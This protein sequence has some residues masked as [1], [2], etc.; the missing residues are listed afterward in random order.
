MDD[1]AATVGRDE[2]RGIGPGNRTLC[3]FLVSVVGLF[4]EL[5][6]I[7]W[8]STEIRIF[9]Y[10]Q[11]TV[12]VVC[13]LGLGIGMLSCRKAVAT[14]DLV[15]PLG[16]LLGLLAMPPTRRALGRISEMLSLTGDLLIWAG[17]ISHGPWQ[18]VLAVGLGLA[19]ALVPLWL[20]WEAFIPIGR[21]TGRLL[22]DHPQTIWAYSVNV[23]GGLAGIW[24]F[25]LLSA[26]E[27]PPAAWMA[28]FGLLMTALAL[29]AGPAG[30]RWPSLLG[31]AALVPLA[32]VAG[33]EPGAIEVKWSHYQKLA[34][35]PSTPGDPGIAG[36]GR[37]LVTVNSAG[38]QTMI[39]LDERR[40]ADDPA[41]YPPDLRGLSQYDLPFLLHR[42][43]RKALVVGAGTGNDVAGALRHGVEEVTAVEIDPAI[44]DLGRRYHPERPYDSPRVRVVNDDARSFFAT[45]RE[46]YDV[47]LFGLLDSHTTTA[48]TNA[49]LDHY[50]YTIE[51]L[52]Q[53]R[54]LLADGG[55]MVL[56]FEAQK[57]YV[58]DRMARAIGE[59]FGRPP[60]S[61]RVPRTQYG[62]GGAVFVA[63]DLPGVE[64][65]L[66][67]NPRLDG[68]IGRWRAA[69]PLRLTGTTP[70]ATDDWPYIYL[71]SRRIPSLYFLLAGLLGLLFLHG[72][73]R[74]G[75]AG[76]VRGWDATRWHFFFMGAAFLLLEV[77]NVSKAAVVLGNTWQVNAVVISGILAMVLLANGIVARRPSLPLGAVYAALGLICVGVYLTDLS[78]LAFLPF[79]AKALIVGGLAGLPMLCSGII[80][81]RSFA[82]VAAKDQALGANIF[83]ALV[84]G[85]LQSLTFVTG[86]RFLLLMVAALYA[87]A[88][89]TRPSRSPIATPTAVPPPEA[90]DPAVEH[91]APVA[92][93]QLA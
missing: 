5:V 26:L 28:A 82:A 90:E 76:L 71:E 52:R 21:L 29:A 9:A 80:F 19:L 8:I 37:Y 12:L 73:R 92:E 30:R 3:L 67:A 34:L 85:L 93:P 40:V 17:G 64:R 86:T 41:R 33:R 7:R 53:A 68:A 2:F 32:W 59:V 63:G 54:S 58:S 35:Y 16:V 87:A 1:P 49:R 61:F 18:S 15:L 84:G 14:R 78:R 4:L 20:I 22:T 45:C 47:I 43:P 60:I 55:V 36:V 91:A 83:G 88:Y 51:S 46:R 13:F 39:D 23:A 10:L 44:L 38:Y 69:S 74:V 77:Q 62:W 81:A 42:E 72:V 48:M 27:L 75:L 50:V 70:V 11:N 66:A 89:L 6:L 25:V 56:S 79:A 24:L 57:P 65:Q 31:L